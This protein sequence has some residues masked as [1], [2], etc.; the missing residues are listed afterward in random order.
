[1]KGCIRNMACGRR[2]QAKREV[3]AGSDCFS[4]AFERKRADYGVAKLGILFGLCHAD[5]CIS[6]HTKMEK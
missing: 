4:Q 5:G 6:P 2:V 1:M 3:R